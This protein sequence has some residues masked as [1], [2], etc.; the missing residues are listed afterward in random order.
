MTWGILNK[1]KTVTISGHVCIKDGFALDYCFKEA[2]GSLLPVCDEV[3][4]CVGTS[5]DDTEEFIRDWATR[6]PKINVC[7]YDWP[8]PKGDPDFWVKW[9]QY[10]RIHC[11][12]RYQLQI[13]GD[14]ILFDSSYP[15]IEAFKGMV[16]TQ[17]RSAWCRRH[18]FW[19]DAQH[20]IPHGFCCS[21]RVVRL[22]PT[23]LFM[24]SD[25][26]HP[27]GG[28]MINMAIGTAIEIG[29]YG[30]LRKRD[31]FYRKAKALQS[32]FFNS[33]DPRLVKCEETGKNFMEDPAVGDWTQNLVPF[34]GKHPA[35]IHDYLKERGYSV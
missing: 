15:A 24:P 32:Y 17:Q 34:T 21:D 28:P 29:H 31:A 19:R 10:A 16:Q 26:A 1:R 27:L 3:V 6:E 14:E 22:G 2:I 7:I 35:I 4:V 9:I 20:V 5:T 12:G 8:N 18:N 25:G 23:E 13:D 30:F 33:Y 11:K